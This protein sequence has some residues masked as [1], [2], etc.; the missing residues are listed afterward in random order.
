[1]WGMSVLVDTNMLLRTAQPHHAMF[2]PAGDAVGIL[3]KRGERL[4]LVPQNLYEFWVV[5]TRPLGKNGLGLSVAETQ[6]EMARIK[7]FGKVLEDSSAILPAWERLVDH[8]QVLGRNAHDARLVA[9][10]IVHGLKQILTFNQAD[11]QR[12]TEITALTPADV[13]ATPNP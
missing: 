1:M 7:S 8:Y 4:C 3:R 12:Y 6:V 11:F 5:C 2:K 10:M 9:A 13:L